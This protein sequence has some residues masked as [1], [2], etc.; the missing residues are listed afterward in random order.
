MMTGAAHEEKRASGTMVREVKS[1]SHDVFN[2][3]T[4]MYGFQEALQAIPV[5]DESLT[6]AISEFNQ[7]VSK[8]QQIG[9]RLLK[10]Y[11]DEGGTAP[12]T[13]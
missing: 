12:P 6:R 1:V 4:V 2:L 10:I 3:M 8:L 9:D 7:I 13:K 11:R 5:E